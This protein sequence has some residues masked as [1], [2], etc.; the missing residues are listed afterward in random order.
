MQVFLHASPVC[1]HFI[2]QNFHWE[3]TFEDIGHSKGGISPGE[4]SM[5]PR[6]QDAKMSMMPP[7][8]FLGYTLNSTGLIIYREGRYQSQKLPSID[9]SKARV[10]LWRGQIVP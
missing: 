7:A 9:L 10:L 8:L 2:P 5:M 6:C 4:M 1:S 3:N